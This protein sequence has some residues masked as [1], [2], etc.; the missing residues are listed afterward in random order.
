MYWPKE[1]WSLH[2]FGTTANL[3]TNEDV[4][5]F[6]H[7]CKRKEGRGEGRKEKREEGSLQVE[8]WPQEIGIHSVVIIQLVYKVVLDKAMCVINLV[9]CHT[10]LSPLCSQQYP[11]SSPYMPCTLTLFPLPCHCHHDRI[12]AHSPFLLGMFLVIPLISAHQP[13]LQGSFQ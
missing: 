2:P 3:D 9:L 1:I 8:S 5:E 10:S 11:F 7:C 4:L 13:S 6:E 12:F